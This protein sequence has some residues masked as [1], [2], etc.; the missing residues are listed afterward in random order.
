MPDGSSVQP[1]CPETNRVEI[2]TGTLCRQP[3]Q[4]PT[5]VGYSPSLAATA[6]N[7]VT[8]PVALDAAKKLEAAVAA[9]EKACHDAYADADAAASCS[10]AVL[11]VL[12]K[13][14]NPKEEW[15][16]ANE[17]IDH[18]KKSKDWR[19]VELEAGWELANKGIVVVGG[20]KES[21]HGHVIVIYP[22]T[23]ILGGD[24]KYTYTDKK[25]GKKKEIAMTGHG[26]YPRCLSRSNGSW[27]GAVSDGDKNVWDPWGKDE[28]FKLVSFWTM[29]KP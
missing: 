28:H 15:R 17:L 3:S 8:S 6:L 26:P 4:T 1:A 20:K 9:L 12:Q 27:P 13:L 14:I 5:S 16:S 7:A 2:D 19:K 18:M 29:D 10:H 11:Y 22:G 24:Y 25:T 21:D 23:K